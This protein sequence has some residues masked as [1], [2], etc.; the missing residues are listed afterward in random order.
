M[1]ER[2]EAIVKPALL[3]WARESIGLSP[4]AA[5]R[6]AQV[7]PE[8]LQAWEQGG[9]RPSIIQLRKLAGIYK[10]PLAV[11]YLAE[12]PTTFDA[13]HDYRRLPG[14]VAGVQSPELRLEI[15]RAQHRR[16]L[17]F[18]L[19]EELQEEPIAFNAAATLSDEPATLGSRVREFLGITYDEQI[20]WQTDYEALNR[21]RSA[22]EEK[23]VLVFQATDV[24]PDEMGG[25]S[26]ADT[27]LP[28]VVMN[29]K[30]SPR[31]RIFTMLHEFV[32]LML[33]RSGLCDLQEEQER[34]PEEQRVEVFCNRISGE[35]IVPQ[36][37]LLREDVVRARG[38]LTEW[39]DQEIDFLARRYRASRET[40]L[41]RLLICGKTTEPFY[42]RKRQEWLD[43]Y[44]DSVEQRAGGF[45]PPFQVALST[46]G[47]LF[48]KLVLEGYGRQK[49]TSSDVAEYLR[50]RLKHLSKLERAL[51]GSGRAI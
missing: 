39:P 44:Q 15:R 9:K 12:P 10:R 2:V 17:A 32:H 49:I 43:E 25:F 19:H 28:A 22:F 42:R 41:R 7:K 11:F 1:P 36:D 27:P 18:D 30:D 45:A 50:I 8:L 35:A 20:E 16:L 51:A 26:I 31:R 13:L 3:I 4:S 29:I 6:K 24:E 48:T 14:Q 46:A 5:A 37:Y 47:P 34:P 23:G 33:R 38:R 40:T 21:W